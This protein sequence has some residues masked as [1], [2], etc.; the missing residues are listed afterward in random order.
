MYIIAVRMIIKIILLMPP[1]AI[2]AVSC[3]ATNKLVSAVAF[4]YAASFLTKAAAD[5][6]GPGKL[7]LLKSGDSQSGCFPS[8]SHGERSVV[9]LLVTGICPNAHRQ[10]NPIAKG[11]C[12]ST[13]L[14]AGHAS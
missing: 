13:I 3:Y 10:C 5:F 2:N 7:S 8:L 6:A 11:T 12:H 9:C 1:Q 14:D 4:V